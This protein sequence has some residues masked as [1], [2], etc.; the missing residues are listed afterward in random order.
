MIKVLSGIR[1]C[2]KSTLMTEFIE[3]PEK[4]GMPDDWMIYLGLEDGSLGIRTW[5]EL[6]NHVMTQMTE[7]KGA[8][9]LW[10]RSRTSSSGRCPFPRLHQRCRCVSDEIRLRPPFH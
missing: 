3:E 9:V 6:M 8:C 10:I 1:R 5:C 4:T 2:G 7:L